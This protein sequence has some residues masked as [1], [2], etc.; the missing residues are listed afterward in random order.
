MG[1]RL[2]GS[3]KRNRRR[4]GETSRCSSRPDLRIMRNLNI[5]AT[6][7]RKVA[8]EFPRSVVSRLFARHQVPVHEPIHD[9]FMTSS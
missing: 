1:I 7:P 6:E 5:E 9:H 4:N 2:R 3:G 8:P